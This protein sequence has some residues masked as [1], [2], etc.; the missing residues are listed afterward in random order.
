MKLPNRENVYIP[1]SKLKEYLLSETHPIGRSKARFFHAIGFD[2][3]NVN[4]LE[5]GLIK[6]AY[7][8]DVKEV[9]S[10]MHGTKYIIEGILKSPIGN[11][12]QIR[13][14]W[15]IDKG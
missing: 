5:Q 10:S 4:V 15:I 11:P 1:P 7:S 12:I 9:V 14:V 8:Q 3:T 13:T 2:E 6:M